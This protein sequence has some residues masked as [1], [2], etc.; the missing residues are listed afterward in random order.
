M[1]TLNSGSE[2]TISYDGII[3][4]A[5]IEP[6]PVVE[7]EGQSD[8]DDV[9]EYAETEEEL[10]DDPEAY[11]EKPL[12]M[13]FP[14]TVTKRIRFAARKRFGAASDE[15]YR[16]Y[17]NADQKKM[18]LETELGPVD[19]SGFSG[20]DL[21][22][23]SETPS[24]SESEDEEEGDQIGTS[25]DEDNLW[26][27]G[28]YLPPGRKRRR[29][30]RASSTSSVSS[31]SSESSSTAS[32]SSMVSASSSSSSSSEEDSDSSHESDDDLNNMSPPR[33]KKLKLT[34]GVKPAKSQRGTKQP[35]KVRA[36]LRVSFVDASP[37]NS[38]AS[39]GDT[40]DSESDSENDTDLSEPIRRRPKKGK[41]WLTVKASGTDWGRLFQGV[42]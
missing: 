9:S 33:H 29:G 31:M 27:E 25:E 34:T 30:S 26:R 35:K 23:D 28:E 38:P 7:S 19:R 1:T 3:T 16:A 20:E 17:I 37:E 32:S 5:L 2:L 22:V 21:D 42:N 8:D 40:L 24:D 11:D 13:I 10:I 6:E 4:D 14:G 39:S 36:A 15:E 12:V 41:R 18:A